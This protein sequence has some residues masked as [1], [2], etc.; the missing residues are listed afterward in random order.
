MKLAPVISA[1]L[2]LLGSS[3][4]LAQPAP[5]AQRTRVPGDVV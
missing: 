5:Q 4:A 3:I 1:F 2:L